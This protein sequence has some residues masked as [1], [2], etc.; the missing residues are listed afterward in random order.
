MSVSQVFSVNVGR[1][2]AQLQ[3]FRGSE[4]MGELVD[5][6]EADCLPSRLGCLPQPLGPAL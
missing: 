2:P 6:A 5:K 4:A 3:R 1:H